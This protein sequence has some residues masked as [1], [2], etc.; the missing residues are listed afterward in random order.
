MGCFYSNQCSFFNLYRPGCPQA[1][2]IRSLLSQLNLSTLISIATPVSEWVRK[3]L[4]HKVSDY[5]LVCSRKAV[6]LVCQTAV[7]V[8]LPSWGESVWPSG[9][10][11][12]DACHSSCQ[13]TGALQLLLTTNTHTHTFCRQKARLVS[14]AIETWP[15]QNTTAVH[16]IC[17]IGVCIHVLCIR[18]DTVSR[19]YTN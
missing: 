10:P 4:F 13:A 12:M 15:K 8:C 9:M 19:Y 2:G 17:W 1:T 5:A 11:R 3:K 6:V 14:V 7:T 18:S 16:R